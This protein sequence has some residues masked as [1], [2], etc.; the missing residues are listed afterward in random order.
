MDQQFD[1]GHEDAPY[2]DPGT[3][4]QTDTNFNFDITYP[5]S[6]QFFFAAGLEYRTENFEIVQGQTESWVKGPLA[7]YGFTVAS[8]GF[9]GFGEIAAGTW[10]R[11]NWAIY[12]D[13]EFNPQEN[14]L[15]GAALACFENFDDFGSTTNFKLATNYGLNENTKVR[16]SFS[17]GFRAPTPGQQNAFNVSTIFDPAIGDLTN[18]GTIPSNNPVAESKGGEARSIPKNRPISRLVLFLKFPFFPWIPVSPLS[19]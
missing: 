7:E 1:P 10:S 3:Y 6:E 11:S 12:G 8:N 13:A 4:I 18:D 9:S 2:F 16:G 17:T 14:W 5:F 15:L 19:I